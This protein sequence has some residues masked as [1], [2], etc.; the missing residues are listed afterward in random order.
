MKF[1]KNQITFLLLFSISI[2][3]GQS[4]S[5]LLTS[6]DELISAP[7]DREAKVK[8]VLKDKSGKEKVREAVLMQKGRYKKLYRYTKPEKQAGIATLSLP[9]DIMWMYM[10]AF[11]KP[12]KISLLSKSQTFTGTDFSY[13][14]MTGTSYG[15]RFVPGIVDNPDNSIYQ[16]EL[17]PKSMKSRYSKIIVYLNREHRYPEKMEY[18]DDN[19]EFFKY[20]TY[21]YVNQ[22]KYW[23]AKEV[24][25][26]DIKKEHS[27]S[28][29]LSDMK[30]DQG[31]PDEV[32]TVE[33][34]GD[35]NKS[36]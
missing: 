26:T 8:M 35:L 18:F 28:I 5:D 27:T 2:F 19:K 9:D 11:G 20:A 22:G 13:E 33:N 4:A 30:F 6:M 14:D 29:S 1:F 12:I 10:P 34:L 25:M 31:I 23:Y 36:E 3:H 32:F 7:K 21:D 24:V 16:L 15:E 17:R